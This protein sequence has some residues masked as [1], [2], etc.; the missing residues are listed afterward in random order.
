MATFFAEKVRK[1]SNGIY[2]GISTIDEVERIVAY[3]QVG[4][5]PAYAAIGINRETVLAAWRTQ[6][7]GWSLI[8]VPAT[9][10]IFLLCL[11]AGHFVRQE[12]SA[13]LLL[14]EEM[15]RRE[16]V[17]AQL[18]QMQKMEAIGQLTGGIAHDFNNLLTIIIG[19]LNLMS[20]RMARGE[21]DIRQ[22]V[23]GAM[24]GARRAATLTAQLLA[25]ARKQPL[26]PKPTDLNRLLVGMSGLLQRTLGEQIVVETVQAGGLWLTNIDVNQLENAIINLAVNARDAMPDGGKLT[27]ETAN[28]YLDEDYTN[29]HPGLSAGQYVVICVTDT[30]VGMHPDVAAQ[31]FEPFFTT[32]ESGRGTGLGLSQIYGFVRQ[33]NGHVKIYSEIGH[34]TTVKIYMPRYADGAGTN[35]SSR[36]AVGVADATGSETILLVEDEDGVRHFVTKA[37]EELGY[38]VFAADGAEMALDLLKKQP[39]INM[40]LTDIVMPQTNGKRLSEQVQ[41]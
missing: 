36:R 20:R 16:L 5:Y 19:S 29:A 24:D 11:L 30:G 21:T 32:K 6:L 13:L 17:E 37:L 25:F 14:K 1:T 10:V 3:R 23:D 22:F 4:D 9:A 18:R 15:G 2:E 26:D 31:A 12:R 38:K 7:V 40:L 34:G 8:G 39:N 27:L 28:T 41:R 35:T 33:S